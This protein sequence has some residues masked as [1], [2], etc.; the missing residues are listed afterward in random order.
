MEISHPEP[1]IFPNAGLTKADVVG[2]YELVGD[3]MA[4]LPAQRPAHAVPSRSAL[5]DGLD[6]GGSH[7]LLLATCHKKVSARRGHGS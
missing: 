5:T 2:R 7:A 6:S 1:V 3:A 4:P